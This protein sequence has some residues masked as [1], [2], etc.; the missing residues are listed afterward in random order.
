M[1]WGGIAAFVVIQCVVNAISRNTEAG[2]AHERLDPREPYIWEL[3]S[4]ATTIALA[5]AVAWLM[6][7][8]PPGPGRWLRFVAVHAPATAVYSVLHVG[9][10]H[11]LRHAIY[12]AFGEHY[13]GRLQLLYEYP[14]DLAAYALIAAIF[15]LGDQ[16]AQKWTRADEARAARRGPVFD[17]RDGAT[18]IRAPVTDIVAA[19][20]AGN[21]VEFHLADGR[22]PLMRATLSAL[23]SQL[24]PHGFVRTHRSWLINPLRVRSLTAEGSG[25]FRLTLDGGGEAP[26][27][28]RF[29]KALETLRSP[30]ASA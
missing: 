24:S 16:L 23:E 19:S 2:W 12:L 4:A 13:R 3:T 14:K 8:W 22:K 20:S 18:L 26:L 10:F 30:E 9:G 5:P 21:Y 28:R 17:I 6:R 25:D 29:P 11:V 15:W 27:S 7:R 1:T